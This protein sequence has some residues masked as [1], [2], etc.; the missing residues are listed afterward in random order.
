MRPVLV[1]LFSS[2]TA[3]HLLGVPVPKVAKPVVV[4]FSENVFVHDSAPLYPNS[5]SVSSRLPCGFGGDVS[6]LTYRVD[7]GVRHWRNKAIYL[8]VGKIGIAGI[9]KISAPS[10]NFVSWEEITPSD[11]GDVQG[12]SATSVSKPSLDI[13]IPIWPLPGDIRFFQ[14]NDWSQILAEIINLTSFSI[15]SS[16]CIS[17]QCG[18]LAHR[19]FN[20]ARVGCVTVSKVGYEKGAEPYY[21]ST[22]SYPERKPF[23]YSQAAQ[24]ALVFILPVICTILLAFGSV[25][26]VGGIERRVFGLRPATRDRFFVYTA[27]LFAFSVIPFIGWISILLLR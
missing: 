6:G 15:G 10:R 7:G 16:L 17:G 9:G 22:A 8:G 5:Q 3:S 11:A 18:E 21:Q 13:G 26:L 20:V 1:A 12:R 23:V 25:F 27:F 2:W 24:K 4:L 14:V 19:I